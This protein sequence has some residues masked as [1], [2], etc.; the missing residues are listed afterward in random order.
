[1]DS[2]L[3]G[4]EHVGFLTS[5]QVGPVQEAIQCWHRHEVRT[6]GTA[7]EDAVEAEAASNDALFDALWQATRD[8]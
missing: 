3:K 7:L 5:S 1:M 8:E 6:L 2:E 4:L